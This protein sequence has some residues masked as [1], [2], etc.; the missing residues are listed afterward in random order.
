MNPEH[1]SAGDS[2]SSGVKSWMVEFTV[3]DN[4]R[5]QRHLTL[6]RAEDIHN[7]HSQ[8]LKELKNSYQD[9]DRVDVTVHRI[10]PV[11]TYTD[12]LLFEGIYS[13]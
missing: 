2:D 9:R 11:S 7:V 12:A 6:I 8:L 3:Q 5:E 13:P 1:R 4:G 10:E